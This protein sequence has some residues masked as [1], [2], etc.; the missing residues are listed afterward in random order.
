MAKK[1]KKDGSLTI[2][3]PVK[4]EEE[5]IIKNLQS[6]KEGV[7]FPH[8]VIIADGCSTD[9]TFDV[10]STY[11]K[12]NKNVKII[13]TTP[14]RSN[15]KNSIEV[16]IEASETTIVAVMM[17]DLCDD[18]DTINTMY[19]KIQNGWDIV[20]ASR[21]M[22][23]GK[24]IGEPPLQGFLSRMVSKTLPIL[25]GIPVSDISNPFRMYR[26]NVLDKIQITHQGNEVSIEEIFRAHLN[27]AKITEV[28]TTWK[29]RKAGKSK[30]KMLKVVPGYAKL[31]LHIIIK[32]R[33]KQLGM[34]S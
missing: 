20:V 7:R 10:V 14:E 1:Y 29:G 9:K 5:N 12:K 26:K 32:T 34:I 18:P 3:I 6:I 23:G 2:I 31:Y 17:G 8:Y 4:N 13:R 30:F 24:R 33:A 22:T 21:Y 11:S 27:G 28:P 15:F 25:S 16:G 19:Q